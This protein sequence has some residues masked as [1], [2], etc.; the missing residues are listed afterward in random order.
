MQGEGWGVGGGGPRCYRC[1]GNDGVGGLVSIVC[2]AGG[3]CW[4]EMMLTAA[5][6]FF[7][8][9]VSLRAQTTG[10]QLNLQKH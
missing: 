8:F 9:P 6:L 10:L 3:D 4:M 7:L 2:V 5:K 1:T